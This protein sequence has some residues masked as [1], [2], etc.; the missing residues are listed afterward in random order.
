MYLE[1]LF[2]SCEEP[3]PDRDPALAEQFG[4]FVR[5]A[6]GAF[7]SNTERA[8]RSDLAIFAAWCAARGERAL[9]AEPETVSAFV[10]AMAEVGAERRGLLQDAER[11]GRHRRAVGR[12][13]GEGDAERAGVRAD[14][15]EKG[16]GRRRGYVGIARRG[17]GRRI[18]Q[19][20]AV[21]DRERHR[22]L[23][24]EPAERF[25]EVGRHGV[26]RPCRAQPHQ[27]A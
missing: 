20:R 17:A 12:L 26:A 15:V 27:A 8:V 6:S 1:P 11:V 14:L 16:P 21:A 23:D 10:D 4:R 18:E 3:A 24:G 5:E 25:A 19:R 7:S 9:P 2:D 22:V 13:A